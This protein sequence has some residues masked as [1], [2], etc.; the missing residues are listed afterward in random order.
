MELVVEGTDPGRLYG[1]MTGIVTPR[2]I[3]WVSTLD[4]RSRGNLAPFSFYNVFGT[5]PPVV[6]FSPVGKRDGSPK[7]T[8]S[9]I[10]ATGEFVVCAAIRALADQVNLS[11]RELPPDASEFDLTGL[12]TSPSTLVKP[13]RVAASPTALE[14]RLIRVVPVGDGPGSANL[15]IGAVV[16]IH[17]DDS[18]F[19]DAGHIDPGKL[20][21]IGRL[22]GDYYSTTA[23]LFELRRPL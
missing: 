22:N 21:T 9:N 4:V 13:P 2:P 8:L 20:A 11:S 16:A 18:L 17:V 12:A 23:D 10:E 14:C 19:D 5:N 1:L 6:V 15:V 7:D 3:A